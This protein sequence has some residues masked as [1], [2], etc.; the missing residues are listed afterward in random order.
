MAERLA[1]VVEE[2]TGLSVHCRHLDLG[3]GIEW[4][5]RAKKQRKR[6]RSIERSW[7]RVAKWLFGGQY[8]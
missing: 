2:W 6:L 4:Q 3:K 7:P 1:T 5:Q 8:Q